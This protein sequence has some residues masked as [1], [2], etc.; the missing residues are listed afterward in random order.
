MP[1]PVLLRKKHN[2]FR[3]STRNIAGDIHP[4]DILMNAKLANLFQHQKKPRRFAAAVS[5]TTLLC[6]DQHETVH[7]PFFHEGHRF[8]FPFEIIHDRL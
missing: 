4:G 1:T 3:L 8:P 6:K 7:L 2:F 5:R